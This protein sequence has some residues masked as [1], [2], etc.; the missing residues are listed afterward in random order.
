MQRPSVFASIAPLNIANYIAE[1]NL[2]F[3]PGPLSFALLG[4]YG[5]TA[6][7]EG[8][9]GGTR[10]RYYPFYQNYFAKS[11][12]HNISLG[13]EGAYTQ[14]DQEKT[15]LFQRQNGLTVGALLGYKQRVATRV[16]VDLQGGYQM[17]IGGNSDTFS[18]V[19]S[20]SLGWELDWE[21]GDVIVR[22]DMIPNIKTGD[23]LEM[24]SKS[25]LYGDFVT[26]K[27]SGGEKASY[28]VV[29]CRN[30]RN[31]E[32]VLVFIDRN[33]K[34]KFERGLTFKMRGVDH[35]IK[36]TTTSSKGY[37]KKELIV[38]GARDFM[39]KHFYR[40]MPADMQPYAPGTKD[41][42]AT[43]RLTNL[44][45]EVAP[46]P[47]GRLGKASKLTKLGRKIKKGESYYKNLE[48]AQSAIT[49]TSA[50]Y[51][52]DKLG[53]D[54]SRLLMIKNGTSQFVFD[55]AKPALDLLEALDKKMNPMIIMDDLLNE[56]KP[57]LIFSTAE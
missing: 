11:I 42:K 53:W 56:G 14:S 25:R 5:S 22:G 27:T 50:N 35:N 57:F 31:Q 16:W 1:F 18:P 7:G 15:E 32:L 3:R 12:F 45:A 40:A 2:E 24:L 49:Q 13:V 30:T 47:G 9:N 8:W 41:Y 19:V 37:L 21:T 4:G 36:W 23:W 34:L 52:A 26:V 39:P 51:M 28:E 29:L 33:D 20:V 55:T 43:A 38:V 6:D 44:L 17:A 54:I 46:T 10:V 48:K